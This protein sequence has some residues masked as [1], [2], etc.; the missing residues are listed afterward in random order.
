MAMGSKSTEH[1]VI[2]Q[3]KAIK[4]AQNSLFMYG[5]IQKIKML[6]LAKLLPVVFF[7]ELVFTKYLF[8]YLLQQA[9]SFNSG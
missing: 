1:K 3:V 9:E 2:L 4:V 5:F 6:A 7:K 8:I